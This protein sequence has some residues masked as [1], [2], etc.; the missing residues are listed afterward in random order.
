M[1]IIIPR[2]DSVL[3]K[4]DVESITGLDR[5]TI[6]RLESRGEFPRRIKLSTRAIGWKASEV[7]QWLHSRRQP[8][9]A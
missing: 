9:L 7:E 2:R 1:S 4:P 8:E 6:D 3:R 5:T